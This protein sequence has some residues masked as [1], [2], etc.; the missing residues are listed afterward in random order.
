MKILLA[1]LQLY[2]YAF[3]F[4]SNLVF[5]FIFPIQTSLDNIFPSKIYVKILNV[6]I[7]DMIYNKKIICGA[8]SN[9]KSLIKHPSYHQKAFIYIEYSI[10]NVGPLNGNY[11]IILRGGDRDSLVRCIHYFENIESFKEYINIEE[12]QDNLIDGQF[13]MTNQKTEVD[14]T[15]FLN[16]LLGIDRMGHKFLYIHHE[17]VNIS[18][19]WNIICIINGTQNWLN[20]QVCLNTVDMNLNEKKYS[21]TDNFFQIK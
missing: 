13:V 14:Q 11:I 9:L 15:N 7:I 6:H 17:L 5:K 2:F 3:W 1:L 8:T 4:V 16:K 21:N 19:Y 12:G 18:D 20:E 10:H